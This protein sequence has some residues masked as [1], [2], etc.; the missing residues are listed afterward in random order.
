MLKLNKMPEAQCTE[1]KFTKFIFGKK[2]PADLSEKIRKM[3]RY[4]KNNNLGIIAANE[5]E[6]YERIIYVDK[7]F[8]TEHGISKAKEHVLINP[9]VTQSEGRINSRE[10]VVCNGETFLSTVTRPYKIN[11]DYYTLS[12]TK[13]SIELTGITAAHFC[14]RYQLLDG[15][16]PRDLEKN[17]AESKST[18]EDYCVED[19]TG[20]NMLRFIF[21]VDKL[22]PSGNSTQISE[23][24]KK[25]PGVYEYLQSSATG[26]IHVIIRSDIISSSKQLIEKTT[27][28]K[29]VKGIIESYGYIINDDKCE[30][31]GDRP[32]SHAKRSFK[33][34]KSREQNCMSPLTIRRIRGRGEP[35]SSR[36]TV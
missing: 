11:V 26:A 18:S 24:I 35:P 20:W 22:P 7:V 8:F 33:G 32:A 10:K 14:Q 34:T 6:I 36:C 23:Q 1:I 19:T 25:I 29:K 28:Y 30:L 3:K 17:M 16:L 5:D 9:V 12:G 2:V 21:S 31:V 4:C 27:L 13:S 15:I